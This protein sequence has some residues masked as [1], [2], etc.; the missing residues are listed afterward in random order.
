MWKNRRTRTPLMPGRK[1]RLRMF[2][3]YWWRAVVLM[4]AWGVAWT[5]H[6]SRRDRTLIAPDFT[7][8]IGSPS[9]SQAPSGR[10]MP[11]L[12]TMPLGPDCTLRSQ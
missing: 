2:W 10:H 11:I 8:G 12:V 1:T 3:A 6:R 5:P 4:L 9:F 7:R